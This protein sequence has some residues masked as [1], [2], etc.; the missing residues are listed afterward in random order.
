VTWNYD[1]DGNGSLV[2]SVPAGSSMTGASR[3]S[4]N[5]AG[6]LVAVENHNGTAWQDQAQMVYDGLGE[7]LSMTA[8]EMGVSLTTTYELDSG[9]VLTATA[10]DLTTAYLYGLG[11][12]AE[13]TDAWAYPLVDGIN[14]GRQL[15]NSTGVV[16][17]TGS[18]TPWGDTLSINGTGSFTFGYF[19]GIMDE[20]TGLIYIGNGLYYDPATG[21]FLNRN[22]NPD[23]TNPYVPW[24]GDPTSVLFGPL[25]LLGM[26]FGKKKKRG[27][28]DQWLILLVIAVLLFISLSCIISD[29]IFI[30]NAVNL[31]FYLVSLPPSGGDVPGGVTEPTIT[32]DPED[33]PVEPIEPLC[34]EDD[35]D[36]GEAVDPSLP[37][38]YMSLS[39]INI[40]AYYSTYEGDYGRDKTSTL[41]AT[42]DQKN[43][44]AKT[45]E[46]KNV[47][48]YL[49]KGLGYIPAYIPE[50][51][52]LEASSSFLFDPDGLCYQGSGIVLNDGNER[53][54]SCT[55]PV[56]WKNWDDLEGADVRF[57]WKYNSQTEAQEIA[58]S[59]IQ[60]ETV[61]ICK[62]SDF[63]A[64]DIIEI[65]SLKETMHN[66]MKADEFFKVT[67][68]GG[69][70]C[71]ESGHRNTIDVYIGIGNFNRDTYK[72]FFIGFDDEEV[73][74]YRNQ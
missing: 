34:D 21:R 6:F 27:K 18:Y 38:K 55:T 30:W 65:P 8:W 60:F 10:G 74:I 2:E 59:L 33:P 19:G 52:R 42:N 44:Q 41:K 31:A 35:D 22:A 3:Y 29:I 36:N 57:E 71:Y 48:W 32:P 54:I 5:A 26:V 73:I 53:L 7:R 17:L 28:Y 39:N 61:A 1:Y 25:L 70:L 46:D 45:D 11:A 20:A 15:T 13:L 69:A 62:G 4:Y 47:D 72:D 24:S 14:T 9:R 37:P 58:E 63:L 40:S 23:A 51:M 64:G 56:T 67:D 50:S 66:E 12:I 16:T 43:Q 49:A 68:T